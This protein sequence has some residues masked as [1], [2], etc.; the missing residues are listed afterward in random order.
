MTGHFKIQVSID[1]LKRNWRIGNKYREPLIPYSSPLNAAS[2]IV[3]PG[4]MPDNL[5]VLA[6]PI[7]V[8]VPAALSSTPLL[9]E[10]GFSPCLIPV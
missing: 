4:F 9:I 8:H 5:I 3:L 2:T 7:K 6:I 1:I 10:S